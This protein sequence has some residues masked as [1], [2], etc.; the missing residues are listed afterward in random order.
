VV[1]IQL[2]HLMCVHC[3]SFFISSDLISIVDSDPQSMCKVAREVVGGGGG[4]GSE[5]P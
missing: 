1:V 4:G 3:F 5:G 2:S